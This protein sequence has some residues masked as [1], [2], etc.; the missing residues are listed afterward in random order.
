MSNSISISKKYGR[1]NQIFSF[2]VIQLLVFYFISTSFL[3]SEGKINPEPESITKIEP[4]W[5]I[6]NSKE[7]KVR[8][9]AYAFAK[10]RTTLLT[11][12]TYSKEFEH[13]Y[14]QCPEMFPE[15]PGQ[16][17]CSL[18]NLEDSKQALDPSLDYKAGG[19]VTI[20]ESDK[21]SK[22]LAGRS[23]RLSSNPNDEENTKFTKASEDI[24]A[25]YHPNLYLSHYKI[26]NNVVV[27]R[28]LKENGSET[29][30]SILIV[31]LNSDNWATGG[32]EID[33]SK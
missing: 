19:V 9:K 29:L 10:V 17:P 7:L 21:K 1:K 33:F 4:E 12:L 20:S 15:L 23:I 28:W 24:F 31:E 27:F 6:L 25:F 11:E 18:L 5:K 22:L 14:S 30:K 13:Q 3:Y 16:F 26:K 8:L 2:F 32:K